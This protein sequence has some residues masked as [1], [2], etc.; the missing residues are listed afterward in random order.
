MSNFV[1]MALVFLGVLVVGL[2]VPAYVVRR[3]LDFRGQILDLLA[4]AARRHV[5][6][7]PLL[8]RAA[9]EHRGRRR[10]VLS[11]VAAEM[12][13][14]AAL[15]RALEARARAL[16]PNRIIAAIQTSEGSAQVS[17][18]LSSLAHETTKALDAR[19][20]VAMTMF[21]PIC[22][23]AFLIGLQTFYIDFVGTGAAALHGP[24]ADV[25]ARGVLITRFATVGV[26]AIWV[27]V[28]LALFYRVLGWRFE[29]CQR[30]V[31]AGARRFLLLD[32]LLRLAGAERLLRSVS[33]LVAAGL[34]LP[35]ALRRSA[36]ATGSARIAKAALAGAELMEAGIS[37]ENAW[38]RTLLPQFAALRAATA[39]GSPPAELAQ[40]L[41]SLATECG[42]RLTAQVDRCL[43]W[44]HP[45]AIGLF[46]LLLALQFAGV[47]E[48]IHHFQRGARLW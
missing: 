10:E 1:L 15:S 6:F 2:F 24:T 43:R 18:L 22:L 21:Y 8:E 28:G 13:R 29:C 25:T 16:F 37:A 9:A 30:L 33:A 7:G 36:P 12:N 38:C 44:I 34:S 31:D 19:H 23:G 14:G 48:L 27:A 42:H 4:T 35:Q 32:R 46:G 47:F 39:T 20:R 40:A 45:I 11:G 41:S 17:A 26:V 3:R 5:P